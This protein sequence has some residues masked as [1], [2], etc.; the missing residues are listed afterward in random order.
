[1]HNAERD[2]R[3]GVFSLGIKPMRSAGA[4][5]FGTTFFRRG[6]MNVFN[7]HPFK[8]VRLRPQ[9]TRSASWPI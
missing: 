9:R 3:G 4:C 2:D 1:M 5:A 7:E 8:A 6:R